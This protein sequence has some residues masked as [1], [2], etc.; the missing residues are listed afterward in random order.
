MAAQTAKVV[1]LGMDGIIFD[2]EGGVGNPVHLEPDVAAGTDG[3]SAVCS[4][5]APAS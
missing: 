3:Y 5:C 2:V 4:V 1:A